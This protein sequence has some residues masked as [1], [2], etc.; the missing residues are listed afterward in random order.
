[1]HLRDQLREAVDALLDDALHERV[2]VR[3][4]RRTPQ[5]LSFDDAPPAEEHGTLVGRPTPKREP[6]RTNAA[7]GTLAQSL[8]SCLGFVDT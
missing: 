5:E 7:S 6:G 3:G 2:W 8:W 1:M 4:Q